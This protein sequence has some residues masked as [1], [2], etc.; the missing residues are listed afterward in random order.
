MHIAIVLGFALYSSA[1]IFK[2]VENAYKVTLAGTFLKR[3]PAQGALTAIFGGL[4]TW[5]L[6]ETLVSE[7][8]LVPPQWV[9][10][11]TPQTDIHGAL[12]HRAVAETHHAVDH[13]H[14]H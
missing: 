12:H 8:S 10:R 4:S 5:I 2:M 3:V 6:V 13:P 11:P 1:S 7:A 9:G 14:Q